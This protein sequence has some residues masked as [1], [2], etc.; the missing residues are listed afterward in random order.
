MADLTKV[1]ESIA[2]ALLTGG[3]ST[4][5]TMF[6]TFRDVR[7]RLADLDAR[8]NT[9][10]TVVGTQGNLMSESTGIFEC[11]CTLHTQIERLRKE[12]ASWEDNPPT[13][14]VKLVQ[15]AERTSMISAEGQQDFE[16]RLTGRIRAFQDRLDRIEDNYKYAHG[17]Y[18]EKFV[19]VFNYEEDS[20][21]RAK[22]LTQL[23]ETIASMNGLLRGI[24]AAMN[25]VDCDPS[26]RK[27]ESKG[28]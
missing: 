15:R 14:A 13:W 8:V 17:Q 16:D 5:A 23:R 28:R 4:L 1:I 9:L 2:A 7:K 20:K 26:D 18:D 3:A 12:I 11:L 10:S 21:A 19:D 27:P 6:A 24:M 22:E 25:I